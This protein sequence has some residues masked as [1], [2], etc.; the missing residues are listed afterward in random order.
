[1]KCYLPLDSLLFLHTYNNYC[2]SYCVFLL[3][4]VIHSSY[5]TSSD[6]HAEKWLR[7]ASISRTL[8]RQRHS[9]ESFNMKWLSTSFSVIIIL[10]SYP[11]PVIPLEY[12]ISFSY[13][14]LL[15]SSSYSFLFSPFLYSPLFIPSFRVLRVLSDQRCTVQS[16]FTPWYW[17]R[18]K[19]LSSS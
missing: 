6:T 15:S 16:F 12:H 11:T 1:M 4:T 14:P 2:S 9:I 3:I 19:L 13:V 17:W 7:Y 10:A 5:P 18:V 8:F